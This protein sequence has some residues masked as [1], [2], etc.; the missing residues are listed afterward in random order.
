MSD[1]RVQTW[2]RYFRQL[3]GATA[4][5]HSVA[6]AQA[7]FGVPEHLVRYWR[8]KAIDPT[9]K[10]GPVGGWR[11]SKFGDYDRGSIEWIVRILLQANPRFSCVHLVQWLNTFGYVVNV[12]YVQRLLHAM[13]FTVKRIG[14]TKILKYT[15]ANL[16]Y[17][18][19]YVA[20]I[21]TVPLAS[22]K[23]LDEARFESR[24]LMPVYG[25]GVRGK[26]IKLRDAAAS[27]TESYTV[28]LCISTVGTPLTVCNVHAGTNSAVD[29]VATLTH[30]RSINFLTPGDVLVVDNAPIHECAHTSGTSFRAARRRSAFA[31]SASVFTRVECVRRRVCRCEKR[32][33][34]TSARWRSIF[35]RSVF[36]IRSC[37]PCACTRVLLSCSVPL[38]RLIE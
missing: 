10:S 38:D 27:I 31:A 19:E 29:F 15:W 11:Y 6:T 13:D 37:S 18:I 14:Y 8:Q 28:T 32:H 16:R 2:S 20:D 7:V 9:Y 33:A 12:K 17:F 4:E 5:E 36:C 21:R 24:D 26:R 30:L 1:V 25:R 35:V 23:F 3:T 22:I 34:P